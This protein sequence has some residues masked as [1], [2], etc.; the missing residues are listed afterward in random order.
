[1]P[2]MG[3]QPRRLG[4]TGLKT[5]ANLAFYPVAPLGRGVHA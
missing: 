5:N 2:A 1:V 4:W 3:T